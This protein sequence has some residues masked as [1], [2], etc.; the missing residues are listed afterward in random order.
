MSTRTRSLDRNENKKVIKL[1][2]TNNQINNKKFSFQPISNVLVICCIIK[3]SAICQRA[4][5][6]ALITHFM[7]IFG[8]WKQGSINFFITLSVFLV[9]F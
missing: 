1:I 9:L 5:I 8:S 6:L 7:N 4:I 2:T 3:T